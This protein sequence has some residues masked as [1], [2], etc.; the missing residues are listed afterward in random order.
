MHIHFPFGNIKRLSLL[1]KI[2]FTMI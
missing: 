1:W 2:C